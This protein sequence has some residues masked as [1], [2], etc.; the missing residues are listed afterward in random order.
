MSV[1]YDP[2]RVI[3]LTQPS[4]GSQFGWF[5]PFPSRPCDSCGGE[6]FYG[7]DWNLGYACVNCR[8][9]FGSKEEWAWSTAR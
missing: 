2:N 1:Q 5:G 9:V 6:F 3:D 8:A 7:I 4:P